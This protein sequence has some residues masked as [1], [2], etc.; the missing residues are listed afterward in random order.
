MTPLV[1]LDYA[2]AIG[3]VFCVLLQFATYRL[4][5]I[6]GEVPMLLAGRALL[7]AGWTVG[8]IRMSYLLFETGDLPLPF[9]TQLWIGSLE[10][11]TVMVTLHWLVEDDA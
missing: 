1:L 7:L 8:A 3:A 9:I 6:N 11:G 10:L 2:I 5:R 4:A